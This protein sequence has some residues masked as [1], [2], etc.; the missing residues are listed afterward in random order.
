MKFSLLLF[1]L[2]TFISCNHSSSIDGSWNLSIKLQDKELPVLISLKQS[3]DKK[4][5]SGYLVNGAEKL[6]LEGTIDSNGLFDVRIAAHYAKL[7]GQFSEDT[8][9]G[10]WIRTN[11]E[12]YTVPFSGV[13]SSLKNLYSNYEEKVSPLNISGRWKL[14]LG[15][16]ESALGN[17]TQSGSRVQGSILTKKGD[18]RYLDGYI[19]ENQLFLF[20]FDGVFSFIFEGV[21]NKEQLVAKMFSG[22]DGLKKLSGVKDADFKLADPLDLTKKTN[23]KPIVL[24]LETIDGELVNLEQGKF[25]NKI[26]IIQ[27]FGSWCPNCH[28]E[29]N[30]FVRWRAANKSKLNDI[31][32]VA[33]SFERASSKKEALKNLKRVRSKLGMDYSVIMADFDKSIQVTDILP[34]N[35]AVAFPTTL[36]L[37]RQNQIEKIHTGFAGQATGEFFKAFKVDFEKTINDLL[38]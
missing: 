4:T 18:Y 26:K 10:S 17:F 23:D 16:K 35:K 25:K 3:R 28:D 32:F 34:I 30:F 36:F 2:T 21:L 24:N 5:L 19:S 31:E 27:V 38:I 9:K 20:G 1:I 37:N 8:L 7:S 14:D 22:K 11:K 15:D 6:S 29:T 12:N 13:R 33:V